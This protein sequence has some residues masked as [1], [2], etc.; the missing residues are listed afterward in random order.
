MEL[1]CKRCGST[2]FVK[3]GFVRGSNVTAAKP[4]ALTLPLRPNAAV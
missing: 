1:S 3:H 4:A 2:S